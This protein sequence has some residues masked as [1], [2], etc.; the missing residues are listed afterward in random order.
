[1]DVRSLSFAGVPLG[2]PRHICAFFNGQEEEY[3]TLLPFI[4]DGFR[5]GQKAV[6]VVSPERYQGH[7][8]HLAAAGIEVE[9]A[10]RQGQLELHLSTDVYL[11]DEHFDQERM[12]RSFEEM[13]KT[14]AAG[15]FGLSRIVCKFDW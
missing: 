12:L 1:M 14:S 3:R 7:L 2:K 13:C 9:A 6:H 15:P 11:K 10:Q 4:A 5:E 8:S